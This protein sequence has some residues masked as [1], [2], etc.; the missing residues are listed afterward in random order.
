MFLHG[1]CYFQQQFEIEALFADLAGSLRKN[2]DVAVA[3]ACTF[4]LGIV[5]KDFNSVMLA[6]TAQSSI[7]LD[8]EN[9][10]WCWNSIALTDDGNR[11]QA[12]PSASSFPWN[13][14]S[15]SP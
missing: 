1:S 10:A 6:P 15:L 7:W 13:A 5:P 8:V 4:F 9:H 14:G 3:I 2:E 12:I 11:N